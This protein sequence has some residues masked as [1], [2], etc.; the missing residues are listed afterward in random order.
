[1][2]LCNKE[3][4]KLLSGKIPEIRKVHETSG[5]I[6]LQYD[7]LEKVF[8][9]L[10]KEKVTIKKY[11]DNF[12]LILNSDNTSNQIIYD[13]FFEYI[14]PDY[15]SLIDVKRNEDN[16][17][18][19]LNMLKEKIIDGI[20][21]KIVDFGCGTGLSHAFEQEMKVSLI[22]VDKCPVMRK[23]SA[24]KGLLV[25][26]RGDLA[27]EKDESIDGAIS[28]Y[29]LHLLQE[30]NSLK[31][32]W[33]K[34]KINGLIVANFHKEQNIDY[35]LSIIVELNGQVIHFDPLEDK[36]EHGKYLGFKKL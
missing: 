25:Y 24:E 30:P 15:E 12:Y 3:I 31:L 6:F 34:L 13:K 20:N 5:V 26:G 21:V 33:S 11:L 29:V 32:L 36:F 19:L 18:N 8:K 9:Y 4:Y 2:L 14:A 35:I 28:S 7:Y 22:G 1:M 10:E 27:K 16:I 23:L 17:R